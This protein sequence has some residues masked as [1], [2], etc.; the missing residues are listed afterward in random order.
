MID[1]NKRI[2]ILPFWHRSTKKRGRREKLRQTAPGRILKRRIA[3]AMAKTEEIVIRKHP[4]KRILD[5]FLPM[6]IGLSL[7]ARRGGRDI[8]VKM[9][10]EL[11]L[12]VLDAPSRLLDLVPRSAVLFGLR[13][14]KAKETQ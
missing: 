9:L 14:A 6:L 13:R 10:I 12:H 2:D 3:K 11:R 5:L 1:H 8:H 4:S 7:K